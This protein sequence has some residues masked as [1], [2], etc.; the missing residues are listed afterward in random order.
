MC[1]QA[2]RDRAANQA[3]ARELKEKLATIY[4]QK[5]EGEQRVAELHNVINQLAPR[6]ARIQQLE[7]ELHAVTLKLKTLEDLLAADSSSVTSQTPMVSLC[8]INKLISPLY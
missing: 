7:V 6:D 5:I 4:A 8:S 1:E 2:E 3:T